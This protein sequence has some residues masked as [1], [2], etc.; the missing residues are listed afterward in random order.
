MDKLRQLRKS[1]L[2]RKPQFLVAAFAASMVLVVGAILIASRAA[3]P[4]VAFEAEASPGGCATKVS[5][6]SSS[7][8]SILQFQACGSSTPPGTSNGQMMTFTPKIIPIE[9]PEIANPFHGQYEWISNGPDPADWPIADVYYRDE[10]KWG[11]QLEK[12]RGQYDFSIIEQGLAA[13]KARGG[14]FGFRVMSVCPECGGNLIPS[15]VPTQSG[16]QPDWNSEEFLSGYGDLMKAIGAKYGNDPRLGYIDVGGYGSWGEWHTYAIDG[17]KISRENAKRLVKSVVDAFPKKYVVMMTQSPEFLSDAMALSPS[18]GIRIDCVGQ[19]GFQGGNIDQ[20]PEALERWK[21]AP[22]IGEWCG[23]NMFD[24]G[25]QQVRDYHI[26]TLSSSNYDPKYGSMSPQQQST[27]AEA[28]KR[29]SY[30]FELNSLSIPGSI[31]PGASFKVSSKWSNVNVGPAYLP[32]NTMVQ[33]RN[34]STGQVAFEGKSSIDLKT[35]LPTTSPAAIED[36]FNLP[37]GGVA[38][39]TYD[40]YVKVVHPDGYPGPLNLAIEGRASDGGYKLGSIQVGGGSNG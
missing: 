21:T 4:A 16:G 24:R 34:Q 25:L 27:F 32:W 2:L 31:A 39:G 1:R 22:W 19:E 37:T 33:L 20:V 30:R 35:F 23:D 6:P 5:D 13:A 26:S 17:D 18:V 29:T 8:S 15:Y 14:I 11:A 7:G 12:T 38:A 40:V 36:T 3:G 28:N 9:A 10:L